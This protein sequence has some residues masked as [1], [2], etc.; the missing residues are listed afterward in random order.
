MWWQTEVLAT[1][2]ARTL[3]ISKEKLHDDNKIVSFY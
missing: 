1:S 3:A 2:Q